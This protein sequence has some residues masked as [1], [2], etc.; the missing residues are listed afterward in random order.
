[1]FPWGLIF[2]FLIEL[3]MKQSF[4]RNLYSLDHV[5]RFLQSFVHSNKIDIKSAFSLQLAVEEVFINFV[6]Y[7]HTD[8]AIELQITKEQDQVTVVLSDFGVDC[9]DI[10][11][12]PEVNTQAPI[13]QRRPGGL[14]LF[15]VHQVM[16]QVF[17]HYEN[18]ASTV[19]LVKKV[20]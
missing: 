11:Q 6:K 1:M 14:G 13:E 7:N 8:S 2:I 3:L 16:D 19:T 20:M 5:F 4:A 15:L 17:Y 10:S 9:F 18:R 12:A